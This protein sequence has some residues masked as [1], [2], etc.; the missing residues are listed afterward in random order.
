MEPTKSD[1]QKDL[2]FDYK[3][4]RLLVGAIAFLL[5][6][7]VI[8]VTYRATSSISASYHTKVRD[9]FVGALFV[10]GALLVAYNGHKIQLDEKDLGKF[11]GWMGTYWKG[12]KKFRVIEREYEERAVSL[13]GGIAA[14]VT[15]LCPT[16]CDLCIPDVKS[17]IH[18][19]GAAIL[20]STV[21]YFCLVGFLDQVKPALKKM[22][23]EGGKAKLR[24]W[25]YL[26]CGWGIA[27]IMLGSVI[28]PYALTGTVARILSITF[29]AETV[30]LWLFGIAWM[31]ASKF[32]RFLVD[33]EKEQL[34]LI[35]VKMG[36]PKSRELQT[37]A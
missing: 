19:I 21:V 16:A 37:S 25:V 30:A 4:L 24:A 34:K 9:V 8:L 2:V 10:I 27:A 22:W 6:W 31:T 23:A 36:K 18:G 15:A 35:E 20:F 14:V 3:A 26:S 13:L 32:L 5:P 11:W 28:A 29:W 33:D 7:V 12:A 1:E 17:R